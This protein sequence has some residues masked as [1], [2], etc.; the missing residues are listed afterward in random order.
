MTEEESKA[1]K[2]KASSMVEKSKEQAP[3]RDKEGRLR[4]MTPMV[5]YQQPQGL[6]VQS[7]EGGPKVPAEGEMKTASQASPILPIGNLLTTT[8]TASVELKHHPDPDPNEDVDPL[9]AVTISPLSPLVSRV[10]EISPL[11]AEATPVSGDVLLPM[12]IF[13]VV[14]TNPP[15][16]VSN[17]LY[18]QRFRNQSVGGEESYCLINLMAVA[19]FLEN[20][21][22]AALGLGDTDK[23]MRYVLV[24]V[25]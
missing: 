24:V 8:T 20:V 11:P 14:K 22:L 2:A 13:S 15:H 17:L 21:D 19:E 1:Q 10:L 9:S 6:D 16:L 7:M 3:P 18:T 23:V 4:I 5:S 12:I 25:F